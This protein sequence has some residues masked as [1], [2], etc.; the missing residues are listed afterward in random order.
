MSE[1]APFTLRSNGIFAG[2]E[3]KLVEAIAKELDVK[4]NYTINNATSRQINTI[5]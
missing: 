4:I 1:S 5:R 3:V 2:I